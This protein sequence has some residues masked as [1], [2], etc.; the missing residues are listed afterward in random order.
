M[1]NK[2]FIKLFL[3]IVVLMI[4]LG[5]LYYFVVLRT[6]NDFAQQNIEK[7]LENLTHDLFN[8]VDHEFM[9]VISDVKADDQM[10]V[11][12]GQ[13]DCLDILERS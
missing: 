10:A 9:Q 8:I 5:A 12:I 1:L 13:V 2:L 3:P 6:V 7:D 4:A 11:R